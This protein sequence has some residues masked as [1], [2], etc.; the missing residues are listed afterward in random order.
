M[1]THEFKK[2][3]KVV[4]IKNG[5]EGVIEEI[6][7]NEKDNRTMYCIGIDSSVYGTNAYIAMNGTLR[8]IETN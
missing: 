2:G 4:D 5:I 3:D 8:P 1:G 7:H 6:V